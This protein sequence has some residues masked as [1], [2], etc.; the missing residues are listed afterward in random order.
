MVNRYLLGS[1]LDKD[2]RALESH[3][4][5]QNFFES[6]LKSSDWQ[7]RNWQNRNLLNPLLSRWKLAIEDLK[8]YHGQIELIVESDNIRNTNTFC[9]NYIPFIQLNVSS[10]ALNVYQL[11]C[12]ESI[13]LSSL[14]SNVK[15]S[16]KRKNINFEH[17]NLFDGSTD[18]SILKINLTEA[19]KMDFIYN[20]VRT[21]E[22]ELNNNLNLSKKDFI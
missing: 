21:I 11:I 16:F 22:L 14:L 9:L 5:F 20:A 4:S 19:E 10:Y 12:S 6:F 3:S 2:I 17:I 13:D 8:I 18:Q 7:N 15:N 1:F